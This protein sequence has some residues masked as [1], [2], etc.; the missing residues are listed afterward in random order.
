[1]KVK[2]KIQKCESIRVLIEEI[3]EGNLLG[4][5]FTISGLTFQVGLKRGLFKERGQNEGGT[6]TPTSGQGAS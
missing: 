2:P 5:A 4:E 6:G 3:H 1:M